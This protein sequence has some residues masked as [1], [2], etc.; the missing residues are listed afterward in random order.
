MDQ[1]T[2]ILA[3]DK[4][5]TEC[6]ICHLWILE[7]FNSLTPGSGRWCRVQLCAVLVCVVVSVESDSAQC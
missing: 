5:L 7:K 6:S 1:W 4:G 3:N 2:K